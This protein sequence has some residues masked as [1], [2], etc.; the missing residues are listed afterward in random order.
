MACLCNPGVIPVLRALI[1]QQPFLVQSNLLKLMGQFFQIIIHLLSPQLLAYKL[2]K[3]T[4]TH[5][6]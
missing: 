3:H 4:H 1:V 2:L 5:T 6:K